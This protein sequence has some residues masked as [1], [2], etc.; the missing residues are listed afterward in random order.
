MVKLVCMGDEWALKMYFKTKRIVANEEGSQLRSNVYDGYID[1][2]L[3]DSFNWYHVPIVILEHSWNN[4]W[5][6]DAP[7][8]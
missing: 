1:Y 3:F 6:T 7:N 2:F 5:D 4:N 8:E